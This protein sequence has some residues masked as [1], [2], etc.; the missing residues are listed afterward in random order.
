MERLIETFFA[1]MSLLRNLIQEIK[2]QGLLKLLGKL[3]CTI[4]R[5]HMSYF[6]FLFVFVICLGTV[7]RVRGI[8]AC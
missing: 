7:K 2:N 6:R 5:Y 8:T 1:S 3:A 4:E